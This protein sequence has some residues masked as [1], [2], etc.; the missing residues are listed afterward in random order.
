METRRVHYTELAPAAPTS[1]H[2]RESETY[3]REVGRLLAEGH[4]GEFVLIS[5]DEIIGFWPTRKQAVVEGFRRFHTNQFIVDLV[6]EWQE[7]VIIPYRGV[8]QWAV[9]P[10]LS[11]S[12][13]PNNSA[14]ESSSESMA[15][16][17]KH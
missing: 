11:R 5:G 15:T 13:Q 16:T 17:P 6:S 3:R 14:S 10:E 7:V 4:A 9:T 12:Q 1:L 2:A 8:H